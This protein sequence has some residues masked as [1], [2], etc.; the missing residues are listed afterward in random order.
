MAFVAYGETDWDEGSNKKTEYFKLNKEKENTLRVITKPHKYGF[1][2]VKFPDDP[3]PNVKM[4]GWRIRCAGKDNDCVLC[5]MAKAIKDKKEIN[6]PDWAPAELFGSLEV[7][8]FK[9]R[10]LIGVISRDENPNAAHVLDIGGGIRTSFKELAANKKWGDP[11]N[12][13]ICITIDTNADPQN[14]Y[15][16]LGDPTGMGPLSESDEKLVAAFNM[17]DLK[18]RVKP[19]TNQEILALVTRYRDYVEKQK[20]KIKEALAKKNAA[21]PAANAKQSSNKKAEKTAPKEE[22]EEFDG[23]S[24]DDGLNFSSSQET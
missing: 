20:A 9:G 23:D 12:Y 21:A 5:K 8:G 14:Y 2:K 1:H 22:V 10:W 24:S 18:E 6:L 13:D 3:N 16:T 11:R 15:S 7:A 17:D 4:A 19:I